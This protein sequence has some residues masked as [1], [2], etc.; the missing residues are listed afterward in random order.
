MGE[1][2]NVGMIGCGTISGQYLATF[3]RLPDIRLTAVADAEPERA[4]ATARTTGATALSTEQLLA[5][6][7]VDLVVNLTIPA[8]HLA[9]SAASLDAG[10][11][12]Y[13]EK[14]LGS[15]LSEASQL[16]Q[17]AESNDLRLGCAPDTV[18][19]TG[20]QTARRVIDDDLIGRP[21]SATAF[22]QSPGPERW[23]PSPE[24]YYQ[25]GGG[26]LLDMG[27]YYLSALVHLLGPVRRVVGMA[28]R[29]L[30]ERVVGSGPRAGSRF[31]VEV[32]THVTA[33]LEHV[34]G[35]LTTMVMSFD[36]AASE[37][38]KIEV[39]GIRGSVSVPDPN[40]FEGAVR[41]R[42]DGDA[43]W[44]EI[45]PS[46]GFRDGGR[47]CGISDLAQSLREGRPHRAS[48]ELAVHFLAVVDALERAAREGTVV[49]V[50]NRCT[51]PD[52]LPL[53][54]R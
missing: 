2:L 49:D 41:L 24:F 20:I 39:H 26:P 29:H 40:R 12:V 53:T 46:A 27:P 8:A 11:H 18:L 43:E 34:D 31:P 30:D 52:P 36:V 5:S 44:Q 54:R 10:K 38:P 35:A 23:H 28:G 16:L 37:T 19:G 25:P 51:R 17:K 14:P 9:V 4:Q 47:G 15:T 21:T 6:D 13:S 33:L 50:E 22:M 1:S 42:R 3:E 7:D 48:A 32:D 45:A